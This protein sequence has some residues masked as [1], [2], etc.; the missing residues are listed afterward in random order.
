MAFK[1]TKRKGFNFFRSYYDVFNE[2]ESDADKLEFIE[3][4]LDRQ[5][6]GKKPDNLRGMVRFAWISQVNS[7]DS[8]VKG[9][10]DKTQTKLTPCQGGTVG[11]NENSF[12][13]S[14]QV[15][16]KGKEKEEVQ[17]EEKEQ[18]ASPDIL[19]FETFWNFYNKKVDR[20]KCE[21]KWLKITNPEKEIIIKT[22]KAYISTT[23]DVQFRKN[24]LT[25]LNSKSWD[26]EIILDQKT[27]DTLKTPE[28][29]SMEREEEIQKF[30]KNNFA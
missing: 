12:T 20:S 13:P 25:Y 7:I 18:E 2:L 27:I 29:K 6:L 3:V 14:L 9:Y 28:Q 4:L 21:K 10:E 23:P 15:Q 26:N 5:F 19:P 17:G 8:Q 1:E 22:L 16:E 30:I 11:V 24:P